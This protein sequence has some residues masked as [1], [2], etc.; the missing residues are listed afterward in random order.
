MLQKEHKDAILS[1][2][3]A[4]AD[5][6]APCFEQRM[7]WGLRATSKFDVFGTTAIFRYPPV[8]HKR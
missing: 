8:E 1:Q 5:V 6:V 2:E 3:C 7:T 4:E